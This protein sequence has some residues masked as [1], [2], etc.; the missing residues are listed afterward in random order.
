MFRDDLIECQWS[1]IP[2]DS[3]YLL[4]CS[5]LNSI[6]WVP[7]AKLFRRFDYE[8]ARKYCAINNI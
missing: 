1:W 4:W 7:S 2:H 3:K 6:L 5:Y 8:D